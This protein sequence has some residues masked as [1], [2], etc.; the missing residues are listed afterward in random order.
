MEEQIIKNIIQIAERINQAAMKNQVKEIET[1]INEIN[2]S[3][4]MGIHS[5]L[6]IRGL[7]TI[8][9][10][11]DIL[12]IHPGVKEHV[13]WL[14]FCKVEWS[15]HNFSELIRIYREEKYLALES[16]IVSALKED[17][18]NENQIGKIQE[19]F[20]SKEIEK[21]LKKWNERRM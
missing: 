14:Y 12:N 13:I 20:N 11:K 17:E 8:T 15:D 6:D 7:E 2:I 5:F 19:V 4:Q 1:L 16:R 3:E 18:V 21:Q 10:N 9:N